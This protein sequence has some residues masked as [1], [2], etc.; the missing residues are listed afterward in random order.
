MVYVTEGLDIPERELA[1]TT[2]RSSGPGGQNVNKVSTRVTLLWDVES[3]PSLTSEQR[4]LLR[5]RLAGR[6]NQQGILR[7]TSQRHRTQLA[8]REEAVQRFVDLLAQAL[9]AAPPRI[10]VAVPAAVDR[11]RLERKRRR[12]LLKHERTGDFDEED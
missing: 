5:A 9:A 4:E 2:S 11:K 6:I 12:G 1:L 7:V 8:N 3:S 10:S